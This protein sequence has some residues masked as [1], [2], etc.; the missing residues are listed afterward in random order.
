MTCRNVVQTTLLV[1]HNQMDVIQPAI[2]SPAAV[3][4]TSSQEF[5]TMDNDLARAP[6]HIILSSRAVDRPTNLQLQNLSLHSISCHRHLSIMVS[7]QVMPGHC[8]S[9]TTQADSARFCMP[10]SLSKSRS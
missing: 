10:W 2:A 8:L 1:L 5:P 9:S 7:G 6:V 3:P 4:I